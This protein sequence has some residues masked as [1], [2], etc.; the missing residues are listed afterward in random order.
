[1]R[2]IAYLSFAGGGLIVPLHTPYERELL[3]EHVEASTKRYGRIRLAVN[4]RGWT[5]SV[6]KGAGIVCAL[7]SQ[8]PDNLAYP[9]GPSGRL[10]V[11]S[12]RASACTDRSC[13]LSSDQN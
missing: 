11:V 10:S 12:T 6:K 7:C 4:G 2:N 3:I 9:T 1:M 13:K 5:I 8:W